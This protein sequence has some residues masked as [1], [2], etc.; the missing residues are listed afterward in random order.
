RVC[1]AVVEGR[2][3]TT[4][5]HGVLVL[6]HGALNRRRFEAGPPRHAVAARRAGYRPWPGRQTQATQGVGAATRLGLRAHL[7][8]CRDRFSFSLGPLLC[9]VIARGS[10][11]R[12][13]EVT[14]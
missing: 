7:L 9:L 2:L 5:L 14:Y 6:L 8:S 3:P 12:R 10:G 11:A 1:R 13:F 4:S